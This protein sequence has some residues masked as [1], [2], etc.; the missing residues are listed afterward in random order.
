MGNVGVD[1]NDGQGVSLSFVEIGNGDF[2]GMLDHRGRRIQRCC[3]AELLSRGREL[4]GHGDAELPR[5]EPPERGL[6]PERVI[7]GSHPLVCLV[8]A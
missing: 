5:L 1:V 8:G 7:D 2:I 6:R 4:N 3:E